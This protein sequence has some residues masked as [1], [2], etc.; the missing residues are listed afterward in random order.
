MTELDST[1]TAPQA[2]EAQPTFNL[3]RAYLK[4][5]SVEMP[6]APGIFLEQGSPEIEM[7]VG[8]ERLHLDGD[9]HEV[10]VQVTL[11]ARTNDKVMFLVEAKQAGIFSIEHVP[12]SDMAPLQEIVCAGIVFQYLRPNVADLITRMGLPPVHLSEVDFNAFYVARH[13]AAGAT[14]Q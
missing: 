7:S 3:T 6:N 12:E 1:I 10:A 13:E 9:F 5:A 14:V 2:V 4:D 8:V 11:T